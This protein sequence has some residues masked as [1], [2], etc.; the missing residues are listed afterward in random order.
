MPSSAKS[1]NATGTSVDISREE[2]TQPKRKRRGRNHSTAHIGGVKVKKIG[3][4]EDEGSVFYSINGGN[5]YERN[6]RGIH[7]STAHVG[8]VE[9]K[10]KRGEEEECSG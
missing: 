7:R 5:K 2:K 6:L 8:G 3:R 9:V 10:K 1:R 4:E